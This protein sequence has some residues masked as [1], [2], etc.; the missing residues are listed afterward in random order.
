[1]KKRVLSLLLAGAMTCAAL[2]G[3]GGN[4]SAGQA[5]TGN[6][7]DA[8]TSAADTQTDSAEK[9]DEKPAEQ[10]EEEPVELIWYVGGSGPQADTEAVLEEANAYL[11]EKLNCTLKIVETD[12]GSYDQKMQMVIGA[13]EEFDLCYTA[14]WSNNF[15]NN[16][17]KN[18]FL[19]LNDL[20]DQYA[21]D[22]VKIMPEAGWGAATV[23]GNIYAVPNM[24]I[25]TMTNCISISKEYVDKYNFDVSSVKELRDLE[26]LLEAVKADNPDMY[27]FA[28][29]VGGVLDM[30]TQAMGYDELAGRH[31]PGVVL[32]DDEELKV[33]NQFELPQ[34]MEHY[35]L[36]YEWSQKGYIRPDASTI[37]SY[38]PDVAAGKHVVRVVGNLKPGIEVGEKEI[39]GGRDVVIVQMSDSWL[40]TSGITATMTAVSRSSK[41][42]EKAVE[43]LNLF[44]TDKYLYNLI[45]QGI[46]GKHYEKLD[47]EY[48][49]PIENSGYAPGAD[50]MYGNQFMAYLKEGQAEDDWEQ[51]TAMNESGKTSTAFGFVFDP[52][53][54][55]NE[56]AS[57][58]AVVEEYELSLDT[59]AVDPA[60][61]MPEFL[62][63]LERAGSQTIIDEIQRQL[64]EWNANR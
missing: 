62:E 19:E 5:D 15:Y 53:A 38:L 18:A 8:G 30:M 25:W 22:L 40:P 48:I 31:I 1:M 49:A 35:Q 16:V 51:T 54:V 4:D 14:N 11:L 45:T 6:Q 32:L 61:M 63:K 36:M 44:N 60:V 28:A 24:Q 58:S 26:P 3:C 7:Q 2:T 52:T 55:Q 23:S 42:P 10:S 43:F 34:V 46:E 64:D 57:V 56:I 37:T 9:P 50:W 47:G 59:G 21:P 41:H 29:D 12:F 39:W 20:L 33:V 13:G 17:N 27:P